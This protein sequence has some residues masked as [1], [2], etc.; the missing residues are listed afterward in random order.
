MDGRFRFTYWKD[1]VLVVRNFPSLEEVMLFATIGVL[2][3]AFYPYQVED[4]YG[5][6]VVDQDDFD[7]ML[8]G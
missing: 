6:V 3:H 8:L 2:N 7:R 1:K 5:E 4:P